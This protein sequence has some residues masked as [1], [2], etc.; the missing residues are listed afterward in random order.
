[1]L[2]TM[3]F[4]LSLFL[5][6]AVAV[7]ASYEALTLKKDGFILTIT[8][9]NTR[10]EVNLFTSETVVELNQLV[11]QLQNDT[12]TKV[13]IFQSGNAQFFGAHYDIFAE[14]GQSRND[15]R[16]TQLGHADSINSCRR[17]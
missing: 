17:A 16:E 9:N 11:N 4:L 7:S 6:F 5:Y 2:T 8:I 13:V 1:M 3:N 15:R 14:P 12:S 10:S